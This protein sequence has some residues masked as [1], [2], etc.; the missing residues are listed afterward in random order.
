M[1]ELARQGL[2]Q[3]PTKWIRFAAGKCGKTKKEPI[4]RH[5]NR[6]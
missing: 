3:F 6:L 1:D 5:W 2:K 4:R